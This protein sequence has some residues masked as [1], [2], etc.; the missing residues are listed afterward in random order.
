MRENLDIFGWSLTQEELDNISQ[1]PQR[2]GVL[3]TSTGLLEP[4]DVVA[5]IDAEI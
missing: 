4:N 2:K 1:I 3:L 5:Q